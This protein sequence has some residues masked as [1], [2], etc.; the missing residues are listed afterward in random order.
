[1]TT[2]KEL[3]C[4]VF[5]NMALEIAKLGTC[6]RAKVGCILLR[7]DG[8]VAGAGY[9]GAPPGMA[10]C[11]DE[12]CNSE[13]RCI[14]TSHAEENALFFSH[15]DVKH[16]FITHEPCLACTRMLVRRGI[17]YIYYRKPYTSMPEREKMERDAVLKHYDVKVWEV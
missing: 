6:C 2:R 9:N 10:H 17:K 1:M 8:S 3:K 5:I 16:A 14:H 11:T 12:T 4:N 7:E 13:N 15:G